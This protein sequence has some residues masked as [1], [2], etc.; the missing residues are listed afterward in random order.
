[1][2]IDLYASSQ[3]ITVQV[4]AQPVRLCVSR[5]AY[6][7]TGTSRGRWLLLHGNPASMYD[8]GRL[9]RLLRAHYEVV[10]VDLPGFGRSENLRVVHH[11]SVLDSHAHH[12]EAVTRALGWDAPFF[13]LGH[14]HGGAVAQTLAARFPGRVEALVLLASVGTPACWSYRRLATPGALPALRLLARALRYPSPRRVRRSIVQAIMT[15]IFAPHPLPP[16]WVDA[17][18]DNV[19]ARPEILVNMAI[20]ATGDPCGQLAQ[21]AARVRA[22]TLF[23]HGDSDSVVSA[24][25]TRPLYDIIR[26]NV[27]A[28]YRELSHAGHMLH[29][30]HP[31]LVFELMDGFVTDHADR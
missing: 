1:M 17:Q 14:S 18:L 9:A 24:S 20:V 10:A 4:H 3:M 31:E 23:I 29:L 6:A 27:R 19:D 22:V 13:L 12:V 30:S 21:T 26:G 8:F 28:T 15:P 11:H 7:G 2:T 25:Y 5:V 16:A